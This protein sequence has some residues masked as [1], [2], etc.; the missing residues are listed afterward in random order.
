MSTAQDK[1]ATAEFMAA[2]NFEGWDKA[3]LD[4]LP[5][6]KEVHARHVNLNRC[7]RASAMVMTYDD[8]ALWDICKTDDEVDM[9]LELVESLNDRI[10]LSKEEIILL[11]AASA[12]L[13]VVL[14]RYEISVEE[15]AS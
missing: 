4:K 12:R 10:M 8:E 3:F 6:A 14:S 9:W 11:D 5:D 1:P 2:T 15:G 13:M 7:L